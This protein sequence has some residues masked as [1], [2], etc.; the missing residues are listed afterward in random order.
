MQGY[1]QKDWKCETMHTPDAKVY[2]PAGICLLKINNGN[3]GTMCN[4]YS[5]LTIKTPERYR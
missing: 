5:T 1:A 4:I 2:Y 3:T